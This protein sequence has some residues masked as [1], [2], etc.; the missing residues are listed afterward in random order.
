[1]SLFR[2]SNKIKTTDIQIIFYKGK[3][4]LLKAIFI[5]K[6]S[7]EWF[8]FLNFMQFYSKEVGLSFTEILV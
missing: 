4:F 1:M 8:Q 7:K 5:F 6:N 3:P 2:Q